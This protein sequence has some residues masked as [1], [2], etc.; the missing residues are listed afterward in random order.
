MK[1]CF[2]RDFTKGR[3]QS[4]TLPKKLEGKVYLVTGANSGIGRAITHD[5]AKRKAKVFML[6]RD[7]DHCEESRKEIVLKTRN[8]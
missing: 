6:C 2:H 7:M 4:T 8:K 5:L 1:K 3:E